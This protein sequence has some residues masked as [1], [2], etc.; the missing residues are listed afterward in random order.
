[1]SAAMAF[2]VVI[3]SQT[4]GRIAYTP[5]SM[6]AG[7]LAAGLAGAIYLFFQRYWLSRAAVRHESA[8]P[9]AMRIAVWA[10]LAVWAGLAIWVFYAHVMAPPLT[11][12][13]IRYHLAAPAHWISQGHIGMAVGADYRANHFPNL[14]SMLL[15]WPIVLTGGD[16]LSGLFPVLAV[17]L[18]W[19][20]SV[21]L[22]A[23]ALNAPRDAGVVMA[24]CSAMVPPVFIQGMTEAVDV[25]FWGAILFGLYLGL[26]GRTAFE[27]PWPMVGITAALILGMKIYGMVVVPFV[28]LFWLALEIRRARSQARPVVTIIGPATAVGLMTLAASGWVYAVNF[29]EFGNPVYPYDFPIDLQAETRPPEAFDLI[30]VFSGD[31]GAIARLWAAMKLTPQLLTGQP[32]LDIDTSPNSS[33]FGR[34]PAMMLLVAGIFA[35]WALVRHIR[36]VPPDDERSRGLWLWLLLLAALLVPNVIL[37]SQW[38]ALLI[39]KNPPGYNSVARYQLF[40]PAIIAILA[41]LLAPRNLIVRWAGLAAVLAVFALGARHYVVNADI[42]GLDWIQRAQKD[43]PERVR[44]VAWSW[45]YMHP[46]LARLLTENPNADILTLGTRGY[47]YPL[48]Y[49]DFTRKIYKGALTHAERNVL[50]NYQFDRTL[51]TR[52]AQQDMGVLIPCHAKLADDPGGEW[53]LSGD[54]R[55]WLYH[56]YNTQLVFAL[57]VEYVVIYG[58]DDNFFNHDPRFRLIEFL[59]LDR[60]KDISV[61]TPTLLETDLHIRL[62]KCSNEL[63]SQGYSQFVTTPANRD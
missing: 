3:V 21:Y 40:W 31:A 37:A 50:F 57:G 56:V 44:Q 27:R 41:A 2:V 28:L 7:A 30:K 63:V 47:I 9:A 54:E 8:G 16:Y 52:L 14:M 15:G 36:G 45:P 25:M 1:M 20:A 4:A 49:P 33:G 61:Y 18:F 11:P 35:L 46:R 13:A 6:T 51:Y 5:A 32:P 34:M 53:L 10:L 42:R 58:D 29:F 48:F 60:R 19:P 38:G 43:F 17:F 26:A 12:D 62:L 59:D 55:D 23:R 24:L 22:I 39:N